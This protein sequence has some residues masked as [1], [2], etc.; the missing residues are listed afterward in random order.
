[1]SIDFFSKIREKQTYSFFSSIVDDRT[2]ESHTEF[3]VVVDNDTKDLMMVT[4][5]VCQLDNIVALVRLALEDMEMNKHQ[6]IVV[7]KKVP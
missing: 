4:Y 3:A 2:A 6:D 7:E 5:K 1:M